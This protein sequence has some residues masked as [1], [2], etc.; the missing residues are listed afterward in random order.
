MPFGL[1]KFKSSKL[2]LEIE[3]ATFAP[4]S[5]LVVFNVIVTDSPS[6]IFKDDASNVYVG[7]CEESFIFTE[8]DFPCHCFP[9]K[10]EF[11]NVNVSVSVPSVL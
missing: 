9:P 1:S 7:G 4:S 8:I 3:Y 5:T 11:I 6:L 2:I 10:L